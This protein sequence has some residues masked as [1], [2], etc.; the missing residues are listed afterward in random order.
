M[1]VKRRR[2]ATRGDLARW[3]GQT[4]T[5]AGDL[6][7]VLLYR[8]DRAEWRAVWPLAVCLTHQRADYWRGVEW[9]ADTSVAAWAAVARD[10][11]IL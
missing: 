3:W 11:G 9:T 2:T 5:Q 7:P 1:E 10:T 4:V 6:L 8:A